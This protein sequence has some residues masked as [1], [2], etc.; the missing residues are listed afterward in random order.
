MTINKIYL[1]LSKGS[2]RFLESM[3]RP[4]EGVGEA[5]ARKHVLEPVYSKKQSDLFI[6]R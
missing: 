5:A 4:D 2:G 1:F 6:K 3:M